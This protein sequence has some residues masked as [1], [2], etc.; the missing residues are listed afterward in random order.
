M[1]RLP[2]PILLLAATTAAAQELPPNLPNFARAGYHEGKTPPRKKPTLNVRAFGAKGD[3]VSD[4]ALAFRKAI[5]AA[6]KTGGVVAIPA[7]RWVLR[8]VLQVRANDVVLQG[9]GSRKTVLVCPL[10]LT[11][12]R[13]PSRSWSWGGGFIEVFPGKGG[14]RKVADVLGSTRRV[15]QVRWAKGAASPKPGEWL[16]LQWFNDTGKDTLLDHLYG[17]VIPRKRMGK[18][19]Q[20]STRARV[21]EWVQVTKAAGADL[22]LALPPTLPLRAAWKPRLVRRGT[23]REVGIEGLSFAFKKA[24]YPGHLKEKGYNAISLRDGIDCWIRDVRTLN[25]DSGIFVNRSRR[26][27]VSDVVIRGRRMHH[28]LSASWS[29]HCLFTRWRIEAPHRHGTTISWSAHRNVFSHGWA[30]RLGMDSHR[31]ASF[32]NLHS[33]ITIDWAGEVGN[34]FRSGGSWPRGPHS[35]R[36][37]VYWNMVYEAPPGTKPVRVF[38]HWE[39]PRGIFAG[40]RGNRR[41]S[42]PPLRKLKQRVLFLNQAPPVPDLHAHQ[43]KLLA[44]TRR[45]F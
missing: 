10:S 42:F 24:R 37:N 36:K 34:P 31:A 19:L 1:S 9:A 43:R 22:T 23:I 13:G 6:S 17:G 18:E 20:A 5:A 8:S 12:V 4:D 14:N 7:G 3:G 25:A 38:G 28:C 35:A 30:R 44:L 2:I 21:V 29:S 39:W 26:V 41:L 45:W 11:D 40:W 33:Q 32:E 15:L 27:T 16:E